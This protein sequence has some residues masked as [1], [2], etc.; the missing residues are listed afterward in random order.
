MDRDHSKS[1]L[2]KSVTKITF[3]LI[4]RSVF[5][6]IASLLQFLEEKPCRKTNLARGAGLD[7]KAFRRYIGMASKLDFVTMDGS[8]NCFIITGN[9]RNYLENYRRLKD[10]VTTNE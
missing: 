7:T 8:N 5:D 9:G 2:N 4:R 10:M 1:C 3:T 6:I